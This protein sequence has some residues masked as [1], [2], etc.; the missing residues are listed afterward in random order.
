MGIRN[1]GTARIF[2]QQQILP[3]GKGEVNGIRGPGRKGVGF[4]RLN[5]ADPFHRCPLLCNIG[6]YKMACP[7]SVFLA[8]FISFITFFC[9]KEG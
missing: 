9:H 3:Y 6:P 5:K 8:K 1:K 2:I 4:I 7:R